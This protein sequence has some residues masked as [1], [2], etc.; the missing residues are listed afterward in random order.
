[1]SKVLGLDLGTNSIG[2]AIVE[3]DGDS[4]ILLDKGVHIFQ[5]GVN[6]IKGNEEPAVKVRTEARASRRHYF[7]KRLRKINLL[8]I[9]VEQ[10]WCPYLSPADLKEWRESKKFP[11]D[12][13]FIS[14]LHTDD[15]TDKNPYRDRHI[16]LHE[17]LDM[18]KISDRYVLGRALYHIVQRRGFLSNRKDQDSDGESGKVK[19]GISDLSADMA[20]A[21]FEFLGDYYYHLYGT[22]DKIRK[23]YTDRTEHYIKE[24]RAICIKQELDGSL[25]QR[26]FDAIFYQRPLKSQKGTVGKCPFEKSK[27]RCQISHPDFEEFRM[28][29]FINNIRVAF[30]GEYELRPLSSEEKQRIEPL[31][32]RKSKDNFDFS[33]I[34]KVIAGRGVNAKYDNG[35]GDVFIDSVRFN[36]RESSNVSGCP[37]TAQLRSLFGPDWKNAICE[38]YTLAAGKTQEMVVND[39]WHVLTFYDNSEKL[40]EW[41]KNHLQLTDDEA[42]TFASIFIPQGYASLSHCAIRKMLPWLKA[43]YRYDEAAMLANM[44]SIVPNTVWNDAEKRAE[45]ENAVI[46]VV[47]SYIPNK[48]IKNDSKKRKIEEDLSNLGYF[49]LDVDKLYHPSMIEPYPK[50]LPDSNG[51]CLL[52]SPRI[53]SIRNPM[54]MRSLL[55]LRALV[56]EL[57]KSGKIDRNTKVNIEL[58]RSLNDFNMRRAIELRQRENEKRRAEYKKAISSYYQEQGIE[59]EPSEEDLLKYELWE[60]QKHICLYTGRQISISGFLSANPKYDIEHTIPRSRGGDNSKA[61]KTLCECRFNRDFKKGRLPSELVNNE[62]ILVRVESAGWEEIVSNLRKE[63]SRATKQAKT[64]IDK[65]SKDRAIQK[66]HIAKMQLEYFSDKLGRFKMKDVP[67]GFSRRQ[68]VD[69]GI[70]GRYARMYM[71]SVFEKVYTVKGET[72]AEFRRMWGLQDNYS[73]KERVNHSHHCIDAITIACIGKH[74]YDRW[75]QYKIEEERYFFGTSEKPAMPKPW[76]TFTEDVKSIS[77]NLLVSH[78]TADNMSKTTKRALRKRG[79]IQRGPDGKV[80]YERGDSARGS[81]HLQTYYG[82]IKKDDEIRYVIRKELPAL[83]EKDINNIVDD[84]VREK[85]RKAVE[86]NGISALQGIV[87]MNEE[88]K[89]PIKKV[90]LFAT[91]VTNPLILKEQRFSSDM[92]YKRNYYVANESNYAMAVYEGKDAKG[93]TKRSFKLVNNLEAVRLKKNGTPLFPEKDGHGYDRL[94]VLKSGTMVIFYENDKKEVLDAS[95]AELSRRLYK[96]TGLAISRIQQYEY[97]MITL[98][99]HQE[100]RLSSEIK[101]RK[102]VWSSND[103]YRAKIEINH[104]QINALVEGVDFTISPSGEIVFMSR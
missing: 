101:Y 100:A 103:P 41:A 18:S 62:E 75:A 67:D 7:R 28:L 43:G 47:L 57:L 85:V 9:L 102:G 15:N 74:E 35:D 104:N 1:M 27:S 20:N 99:H 22:G 94:F 58:S 17:K 80:K 86:A 42:M 73:K 11:L 21:G 3:R 46:N 92:E 87:W 49:D 88:K 36:Y 98:I 40:C 44:S 4:T 90:R 5:E 70:I 93:K 91:A 8:E 24:F 51:I 60:E 31:F 25:V 33:D 39:V 23:N 52:Q 77:D 13:D 34:S 10:Q 55:R 38:Q 72:T 71:Q 78:Y 65:E 97:G 66:R 26:I 63:I 14:W 83:S 95:E 19:R 16:C 81:L 68:G 30:P 54:A 37:V 79:V 48:E 82:A 96:I 59:S 89:I 32:Y 2:W 64:A 61:N 53:D 50:S 12:P 45:I 69:I 6:R 29:S 84:V 56:N 76:S